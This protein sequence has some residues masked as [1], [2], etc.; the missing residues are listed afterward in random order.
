[1]FRAAINEIKTAQILFLFLTLI[2][3]IIYP[4]VVTGLA[5]LLFPEQANGSLIKQ[6][7]KTIGSLLIGQSFTD[8]K[9]FWGRPSATSP[10]PYNG[11]NSSGSNMGPSN[12]AFIKAVQDRVL[13]FRQFDTNTQS[14]IPVDLVTASGSGLDAEISPLAAY[15]QVPRIATVRH[16]SADA[17][18]NFG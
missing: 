7:D 15:Y 6:G 5:Q 11:V 18:N 12:P 16:L 1:M 4:L 10:F 8:I 13:V 17:L 14:L 9:Y 2:T 3:G